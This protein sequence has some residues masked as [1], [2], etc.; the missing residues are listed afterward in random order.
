MT[1]IAAGH[2]LI[3]HASEERHL[4][5]R[6]TNSEGSRNPE[7]PMVD[8]LPYTDIASWQ[9]TA[10]LAGARAV[11]HALSRTS[12]PASDIDLLWADSATQHQTCPAEAPRI[13]HLLALRCTAYDVIGL[14]SALPLHAQMLL[15][16]KPEN[17]P[18]LMALVS[19]DV[20][21][22]NSSVALGAGAGALLVSTSPHA[23]GYEIEDARYFRHS[24]LTH[25]SPVTINRFGDV[26]LKEKALNELVAKIVLDIII[27]LL[28]RITSPC[29]LI[30]PPLSPFCGEQ[31]F[32]VEKRLPSHITL[33]NPPIPSLLPWGSCPFMALSSLY[34]TWSSFP[35]V[36][37][38]TG[39]LGHAAG[40][41][42]F[43]SKGEH[44]PVGGV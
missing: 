14:S 33:L 15:N 8:T 38:I 34:E 25:E 20:P 16:S 37:V 9:G 35:R 43:R 39:G 4:S 21:R 24:Y 44:F 12:H 31:C 28:P 18:P 22:N 40:Y 17:L 19:T 36:C 41:V 10:S 29:A 11:A 1:I 5:M 32:E 30:L 13:A 2:A 3:D 27:E 23:Q 26:S 7:L 42:I 6:Y